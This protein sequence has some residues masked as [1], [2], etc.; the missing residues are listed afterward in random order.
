MQSVLRGTLRTALR[1]TFKGIIGLPAPE[2]FQRVWMR[3][4]TGVT[5]RAKGTHS[6]PVTSP[7]PGVW[8]KLD[9]GGDPDRAVLYLHGGGYT[10]GS[11]ATHTAMT[12]NLA[13][14]AG[15]AVLVPD[16]RLA[17]EHP[18]PAALEDALAAYESLLQKYDATSL[19]IA[20][21]SA[22]GNLTLLLA[23]ALRDAGK[24][25]PAM[26]VLLSPWTDLTLS[27]ESH[28]TRASADPMLA[29][30]WL[31][32]AGAA[33]RGPVA[34]ED[35][36]VSP[37]FADLTG[38]PRTLIQ[39][40]GD[41]ILLSDA[42]RFAEKAKA[43]GVD[44]ELQVAPGMWHD[45]QIHAGVLKVSDDAYARIGAFVQRGWQEPYD[46]ARMANP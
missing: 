34:A 25:L 18:Y 12:S 10:L 17:P 5:L 22:G 31:T 33:F 35:P 2:P 20:G 24:P 39:V 27:G 36:C 15:A 44:I 14:A 8:E 32:R 7:V 13:K 30:S 28:T 26:L 46:R 37:L 11:H 16:Y 29:R 23:L 45:Y 42:E 19:C 40:G 43:A 4:V 9:G 1:A 21:D 3:A 41:E 6:E 38:L